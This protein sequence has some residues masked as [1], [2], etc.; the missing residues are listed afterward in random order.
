MFSMSTAEKVLLTPQEYLPV[1]IALADIYR[2]IHFPDN[3]P[4]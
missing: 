3:S 4:Q 1:K 2:G